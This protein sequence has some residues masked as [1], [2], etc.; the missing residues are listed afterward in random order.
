MLQTQNTKKESKEGG[1]KKKKSNKTPTLIHLNIPLGKTDIV[2]CLIF[3]YITTKYIQSSFK[4]LNKIDKFACLHRQEY[5]LLTSQQCQ[6]VFFVL[7]LQST[8]T[9]LT[10]LSMLFIFF[11]HIQISHCLPPIHVLYYYQ[12]HVRHFQPHDSLKFQSPN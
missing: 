3:Y 10:K 8:R 5:L 9:K 12:G 1:G 6:N 7:F 11:T 2:L 4:L